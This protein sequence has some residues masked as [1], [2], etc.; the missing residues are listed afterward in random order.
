MQRIC[1]SALA[2]SMRSLQTRGPRLLIEE[3]SMVPNKAVLV[4]DE[5]RVGDRLVAEEASGLCRSEV[6]VVMGDEGKVGKVLV[7]GPSSAS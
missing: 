3:M 2:A 1:A 5:G 6:I 7:H 4:S